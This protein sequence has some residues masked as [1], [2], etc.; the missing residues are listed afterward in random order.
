[1]RRAHRQRQAGREAARQGLHDVC[2]MTLTK[3]LSHL[4]A[5]AAISMEHTQMVGV[6]VQ[7]NAGRV[8]EPVG[9]WTQT[10]PAPHLRLLYS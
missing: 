8:Q 9:R 5:R 2:I 7:G 1:M 10:G 6:K 4:V 3:E